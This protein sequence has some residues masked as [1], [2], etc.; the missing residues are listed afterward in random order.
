MPNFIALVT[1][2]DLAIYRFFNLCFGKHRRYYP[3]SVEMICEQDIHSVKC[4]NKSP[5][6]N[7]IPGVSS[8]PGPAQS[9]DPNRAPGF[10]LKLQL[11]TFC[12]VHVVSCHSS[13]FYAI[14]P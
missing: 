8:P 5:G 13:Y 14:W 9:T 12:S 3:G 7:R 10:S 6:G 2:P 4:L 11:D 1:V